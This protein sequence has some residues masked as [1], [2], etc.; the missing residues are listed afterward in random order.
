M[1]AGTGM[2]GQE[3]APARG[4]SGTAGRTGPV[5]RWRVGLKAAMFAGAVAVA[6]GAWFWWQVA[7]GSPEVLPLSGV[8]SADGTLPADD[9][10]AGTGRGEGSGQDGSGAGGMPEPSISPAVP[11]VLHV[12][13]AVASPGVVELPAGSRVHDA[14]A[15]AGG[16]TPAADLGRLNLAS[17][18][19]DGQK[20]HVPAHGEALPA[21]V[22]GTA[23]EGTGGAGG[24]SGAGAGGTGA[25]GTTNLNTAGVEELGTLPRVGPVLAQRIVDWRKEH[26]PFTSVEELDAVDGVGPKMLETLLP[27]VSVG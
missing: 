18:V 20:I 22:A 12:A 4:A 15:A 8:T 14:I 27:L 23:A 11:V 17:V 26:G 21:G 13:G 7:S 24:A 2:A 3:T 25:G 5:L 19:A 16:S 9:G 6:L 1:Y 10:G